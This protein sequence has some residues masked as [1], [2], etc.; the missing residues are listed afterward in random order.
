MIFADKCNEYYG[1]WHGCNI[2]SRKTKLNKNIKIKMNMRPFEWKSRKYFNKSFG[3]LLMSV[4][5]ELYRTFQCKYTDHLMIN[6]VYIIQIQY[7]YYNCFSSRKKAID[8]NRMK[9]EKMVIFKWEHVE[10]LLAR[11]LAWVNCRIVL[12]LLRI[13]C[14]EEPHVVVHEWLTLFR[15]NRR[16]RTHKFPKQLNVPATTI[17]MLDVLYMHACGVYKRMKLAILKQRQ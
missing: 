3:G 4:D 9:R 15:A 11:S 14:M 7:I 5:R 17:W 1:Q 16:Q 6:S 10:S 12:R 2:N 13:M 8:K